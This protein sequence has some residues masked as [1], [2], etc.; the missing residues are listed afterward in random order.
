MENLTYQQLSLLLNDKIEEELKQK[1]IVIDTLSKEILLLKDK[2]NELQKNNI[3][4]NE[5]KKENDRLNKCIS[6]II[7]D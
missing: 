5:L 3:H 2:V 4:Y 1:Q 6:N 7:G